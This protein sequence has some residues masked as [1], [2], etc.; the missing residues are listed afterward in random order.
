MRVVLCLKYGEGE[1]VQVGRKMVNLLALV[2]VVRVVGLALEQL[3]QKEADD[4]G[5]LGTHSCNHVDFWKTKALCADD[6]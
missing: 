4:A 3:C 6:S 1:G 5:T 2:G